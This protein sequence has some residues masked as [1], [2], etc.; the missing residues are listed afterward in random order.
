MFTKPDKPVL[1]IVYFGLPMETVSG[2]Q[3]ILRQTCGIYDIYRSG[4]VEHYSGYQSHVTF[5]AKTSRQN[6]SLGGRQSSHRRPKREI[7]GN[8]M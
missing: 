5:S 3:L 1:G 2:I 7:R 6:L 4:Q 8:R